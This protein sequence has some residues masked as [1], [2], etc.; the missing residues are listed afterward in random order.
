MNMSLKI[1]KNFRGKTGS[2]KFDFCN[3]VIARQ[4]CDEGLRYWTNTLNKLPFQTP[5]I[6]QTK[7]THTSLTFFFIISFDI[8]FQRAD[9]YHKKQE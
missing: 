9:N 8:R 7:S 6:N 4:F 5:F 1:F 2:Q 3:I